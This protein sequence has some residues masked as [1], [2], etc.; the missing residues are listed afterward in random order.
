MKTRW[1]IILVLLALGS[2]IGLPVDAHGQES[3]DF[4]IPRGHF[5]TQGTGNPG[6]DLGF[7]ITDDG[8]VPFWREFQRLG[9]PEV[10]GYPISQRFVFRGFLHQATQKAVLQWRPESSQVAFLNVF[11]LLHDAGK[12]G[13]LRATR[14]TPEPTDFTAEEAGKP[15]GQVVT[16]RLSLLAANPAIQARYF[17]I[18]AVIDPTLIYGLPT[19]IVEDMGNHFAIRLQRT[20]IQQWKVNTPWA[21]AGDTTIANGGEIAK[22]F[23]LI[24]ARAQEPVS[25]ESLG[26]VD[27]PI[28]DE[29]ALALS[30]S[31]KP[32]VVRVVVL[33]NGFGS[34]FVFDSSGLILTNYHVVQGSVSVLV[35]VPDGR[36][37][38]GYVVGSDPSVDIAILKVDAPGLKA[39]PLGDSETVR[40]GDSVLAIGYSPSVID[41]PSARVGKVTDL[42]RL[43][44]AIDGARTTVIESDVFLHPGDSGSPLLNES[45]QVIG[46]NTSILFPP[47]NETLVI[48]R[49]VSINLV[50]LVI[51]QVRV[52]QPGS[53][54]Q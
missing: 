35:D 17:A 24:P 53:G 51:E 6:G 5:Y 21:A 8:G 50:K 33:G 27:V 16:Q 42:I 48:S 14:S 45:G 15:F 37:L 44:Q 43:D 4:P 9:G 40:V 26:T 25:R 34:G 19:S 41:P 31:V 23:G 2:Q 39:I 36:V 47:G 54:R 52:R 30:E 3:S 29:Q 20:V 46:I 28:P 12:D 38:S 10:L 32:S 49:S 13:A 22:E 18:S 7:R 1:L 11:D